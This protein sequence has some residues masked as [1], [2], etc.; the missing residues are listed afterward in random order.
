[1]MENGTAIIADE[2]RRPLYDGHISG[3]NKINCMIY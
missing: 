2:S 3:K 1:M